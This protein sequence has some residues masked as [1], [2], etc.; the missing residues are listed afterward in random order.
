MDAI[1][2]VNASI[3]LEE[4]AHIAFLSIMIDSSLDNIK[5][6]LLNK[7]YLRKHGRNACYGQKEL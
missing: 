1:D 5:K 3:Y 4:I 7:H 6:S 2:A